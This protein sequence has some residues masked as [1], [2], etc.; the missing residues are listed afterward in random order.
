MEKRFLAGY[1]DERIFKGDEFKSKTQ[2]DRT[3]DVYTLDEL[4]NLP[5]VKRIIELVLEK[6]NKVWENLKEEEKEHYLMVYASL[7]EIAGILIFKSEKEAIQHK[8]SILAE[9]DDIE[10]RSVFSH[11]INDFDS[12]YK[13]VYISK[14]VMLYY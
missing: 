13:S 1:Y 2:F 8:K 14:W 11:N 9:L 12:Y 7:D 6:H 3:V 10:T 4:S 5:F